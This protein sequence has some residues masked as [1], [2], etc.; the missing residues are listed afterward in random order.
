MEKE[1]YDH[2]IDLIEGK[3]QPDPILVDLNNWSKLHMG[4]EIYDYFCEKVN[5]LTRLM[6][7]VWDIKIFRSLHDEFNYDKIKQ[8]MYANAFSRFAAKYNM[9]EDYHNPEKIF[10]AYDFIEN[11]LTKRSLKNISDIK[12]IV[13][14]LHNDISAVVQYDKILFV[15]Y[16]EEKQ[17]IKH[18]S[19]GVNEMIKAKIN[20]LVSEHDLYGTMENGAWVEFLS[21][22]FLDK[23]FRGSIIYYMH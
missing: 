5:G 2:A 8:T 22:E 4:I 21:Q 6:L 12:E 15:L 9:H 3:I 16:K 18:E 14:T 20:E 1:Q 11:E 19:D 7:V 17:K 23:N 10:V 13:K